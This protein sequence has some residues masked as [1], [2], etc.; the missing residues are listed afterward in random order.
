MSLFWKGFYD[1]FNSWALGN[2]VA[3][4]LTFWGCVFIFFAVCTLAYFVID[5]VRKP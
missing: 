2:L 3:F 5:K 4:M 1:F